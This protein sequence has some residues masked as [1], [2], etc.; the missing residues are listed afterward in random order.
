L[1]RHSRTF[2][3]GAA[4]RVFTR[5]IVEVVQMRLIAVLSLAFLLS[6][7]AAV[8]VVDTAVSVTATVVET[9][10]DVTA[11]A[12][13]AVAGSSKD[14]DEKVDCDDEDNKDK[15]VCKKKAEKPAS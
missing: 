7:C 2:V 8:A 15:D 12:V 9:T 11:G 4:G 1:A 5:R 14:D 13:R 3:D 10:V 6:G